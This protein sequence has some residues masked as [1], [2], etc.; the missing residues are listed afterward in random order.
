MRTV[1]GVQGVSVSLLSA[2]ASVTYSLQHQGGKGDSVHTLQEAAE[3]LA[4]RIQPLGFTCEQ[5][6]E[7]ADITQINFRFLSTAATGDSSPTGDSGI[8]SLHTALESIEGVSSVNCSLATGLVSVEFNSDLVGARHLQQT[9]ISLGFPGDLAEQQNA[10]AAHLLKSK[11]ELR[12]YSRQLLGS[13]IFTLPVFLLSMVVP[14]IAS[15]STLAWLHSQPTPGLTIMAALLWVL[16]TPVQFIF[17]A[18]FYKG[19]YR[20]VVHARVANMD[21]L[22]ALGTT[23]AYAYSAIS[24]LASMSSGDPSQANHDSH[25]FETSVRCHLHNVMRWRVFVA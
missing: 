13:A 6:R 11:L 18:R 16:T 24:I 19:G 12:K 7:G 3:V 17:G 1:P 10:G 15:Q 25:F 22:V 9:I 2:E 4:K 5:M 20:S 8:R 21:V 14:H 23:A